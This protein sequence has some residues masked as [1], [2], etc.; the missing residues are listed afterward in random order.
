ML[1][2][3]ACGI[4]RRKKKKNKI[5]IKRKRGESLKMSEKGGLFKKDF[6]TDYIKKDI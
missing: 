5:K 6:Y 4:K 2:F 3:L 1:Y